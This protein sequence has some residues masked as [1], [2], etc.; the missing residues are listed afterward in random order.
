MP[1]AETTL[2]RTHKPSKRP[3]IVIGFS[4]VVEHLSKLIAL[5]Y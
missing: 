2:L 3:I 5:N 1:K 4:A